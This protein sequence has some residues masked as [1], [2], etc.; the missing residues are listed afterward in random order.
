MVYDV[1]HHI[2]SLLRDRAVPLVHQEFKQLVPGRY[3]ESGVRHF[4]SSLGIKNEVGRLLF[5]RRE[6]E[7]SSEGVA[8]LIVNAEASASRLAELS[9]G[10]NFGASAGLDA[11]N[12]LPSCVALVPSSPSDGVVE[13]EQDCTQLSATQDGQDGI[14]HEL[15]R[16][17]REPRL[18]AAAS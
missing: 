18:K 10:G 7:R 14:Q 11:K 13:Q 9:V 16:Q 2:A 5:P 15:K 17:R 3:L 4:M 12:L 1:P 6:R 8:R